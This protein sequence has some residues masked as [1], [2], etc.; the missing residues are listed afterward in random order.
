MCGIVG[1][2]NGHNVLDHLIGGLQRLEYRG[3]DSSGVALMGEGPI[4][5]RRAKGKLAA[6]ES[7]LQNQPVAGRAGI[8]H[9]RWATHGA[10]VTGNAHPH[11]DAED[12]PG[13]A[14]V[15]NGIIE[16]YASLRS[17]LMA[18]GHVFTS[19]TDSEVIP[20]LIASYR[21]VG[22]DTDEAIERTI[23]R[24][25][26]S[27][28]LGILVAGEEGRMYAARKGS[29]LVLGHRPDATFIASDALALADVTDQVTYLEEGDRVILEAGW[30][31]IRDEHGKLRARPRRRSNANGASVDKGGFR[32]FMMKEIHE[33]PAAIRRTV[34]GLIDQ[35][36]GE[37]RATS[38][39]MNFA[40]I[41]RLAIIAC[42]TSSFAGDVAKYWFEQLAGLPCD[43]DIASEYRY[44]HP[45][46]GDKSAAMFISQSGETADTLAALRYV[47][48]KGRPTLA[49]VNVPSSSMAREADGF[50]QTEA[51]P[52]I[53]VA[54]TKAFT[55]QLAVLASLAIQAGRERG[56]LSEKDEIELIKSLAMLPTKLEEMLAD[57]Q[58]IQSAASKFTKAAS[59]LFIGRGT[60][61]PIAMEGALKL[62][63]ITY[64]HAEGYAAGELKH[65]PLALIDDEMPVVVIAPHDELF[66]KT[67]S[68]MEEVKA[69]GGKVMLVTDQ[70][71]AEAAGD[72]ADDILIVPDCHDVLAPLAFVVPLQLLAYHVALAK[73][74]DVD[75]PRNLAKS[76]TVE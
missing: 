1:A 57:D 76:V 12:N 4:E 13:V 64:I 21:A 16:N 15:H 42:G 43:V 56:T 39:P 68:N 10:P 53:G 50:V 23:E 11:V 48:E 7:V 8:A 24:L 58:A 74:T 18:D 36:D 30:N 46:I 19:E 60:A 65:G 47:K 71:G 54:S 66:A 28:A 2:V 32:H 52:E 3:Y 38:L 49:C 29:P 44:R 5:R 70:T 51:G 37:L 63:E 6:L 9:T 75:Q 31:E 72:V 41:D 40:D 61:Y 69:R 14:V 25:D 33:Q 67:V 45:L 35:A 22:L 20:H 73:G 34:A 59:A 55:T 26:G 27:F 17:E 62:K